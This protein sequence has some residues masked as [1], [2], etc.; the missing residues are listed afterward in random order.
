MPLTKNL[1]TKFWLVQV[2]A[3]AFISLFVSLG[4]WQLGRG[5]IKADIETSLNNPNDDFDDVRLPI[6][7]LGSVRYKKIKLYGEY[8][9]SQQFLLDNQVRDRVVG[10]NVLT[11]FY[12]IQDKK[13]LL[14]DRG[15]IPQE[16]SR[17]EFPNV[18]FQH[19]PLQ[20]AGSIYV[21]YDKPY[22]LGEIAEGEDKGWPRRIQFVDYK[23]L[24]ERLG[25]DL[26]PLTLRLDVNEPHGYQRDWESVMLSSDKHYGYSFQWFAMAFAVVVLWWI[27]SIKPLLKK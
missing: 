25:V 11:P 15:W 17:N 23:Q 21:P 7:D 1:N 3:L 13:W 27:Y 14:I 16:G 5:D 4:V 12:V 18:G 20:L 10:Y 24:S 9:D 19:S 22:S 6:V 26:E 2:G 8:N